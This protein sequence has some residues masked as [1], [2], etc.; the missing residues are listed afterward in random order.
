M[1]GDLANEETYRSQEGFFD[2]NE[3]PKTAKD[4]RRTEL[5]QMARGLR[6]MK[7]HLLLKHVEEDSKPVGS[8]RDLFLRAA[9]GEGMPSP[10]SSPRAQVLPSPSSPLASTKDME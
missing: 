2:V 7:R 6:R 1:N 8:L 9:Y 3:D 4:E 10:P 5:A